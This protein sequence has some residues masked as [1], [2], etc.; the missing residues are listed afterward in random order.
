MEVQEAASRRSAGAAADD[1]SR[2]SRARAAHWAPVVRAGVT[3]RDDE[4]VR[5]GEFRLAP[6]RWTDRGDAFTWAVTATWDLP[7]LIFAR[8]ETQLVHA[9]IHAAR[10]R[11]PA[12]VA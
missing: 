7:Q 10:V 2:L 8:D 1:G 6:I 5:D 11:E 4:R 9:H 3:G 12:G